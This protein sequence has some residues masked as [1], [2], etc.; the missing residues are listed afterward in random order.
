MYRE[1]A[2]RALV[3]AIFEALKC[4]KYSVFEASELVS[5]K[6]L[7]LKHDYRCQ[8]CRGFLQRLRNALLLTSAFN[9]SLF[10]YFWPQWYSVNR[11]RNHRRSC[12][13]IKPLCVLKQSGAQA[14]LRAIH[15]SIIDLSN[16]LFMKTKL[17]F[18]PKFLQINSLP[19]F[20]L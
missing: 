10:K 17:P 16:M 19:V 7:L 1:S 11:N 6:T 13:K 20:F 4:L 3:K 9:K 14:Q 18:T 15:S 2:N 5:T 12:I 8:G